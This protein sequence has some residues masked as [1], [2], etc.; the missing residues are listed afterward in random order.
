MQTKGNL[1]QSPQLPQSHKDY[2]EMFLEESIRAKKQKRVY[3]K[4]STEKIK[5]WTNEESQL[6]EEFIK[7]YNHIFEGAGNKRIT[8]IFIFMAEF[9]GTKSASQCR[10][11]HQKFYKRF[12]DGEF[13]D[14][15][16]KRKK[17][18]KK[19]GASV[20]SSEETSNTQTPL[21]TV[22]NDEKLG[23]H[24]HYQNESMQTMDESLSNKPSDSWPMDQSASKESE[25]NFILPSS[26]EENEEI[27]ENHS[28]FKERNDFLAEDFSDF[29]LF[30]H[31]NE[32]PF[33]DN[34]SYIGKFVVNPNFVEDCLKI[35]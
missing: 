32:N 25:A 31:K 19:K 28:F 27:A 3:N 35:D 8:K 13:Q 34:E 11:H 17:N 14:T 23:W 6:Y 7:K 5:R 15:S 1:A 10:S 12:K 29:D 4:K 9:I 21:T 16:F 26:I 24:G 22:H 18:Y 2:F 33:E 30:K 20:Q